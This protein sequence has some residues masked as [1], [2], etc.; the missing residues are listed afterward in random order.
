VGGG[1]GARGGTPTPPL[2][3][4]PTP[5][6]P[7]QPAP[8][9]APQWYPL[10]RP[11]GTTIYPGMQILAVNLWAAL[12][13]ASLAG[14]LGFSPAMSLND[15]C[16]FIPAWFG[17]VASVLVGLLAA[18]ASGSARAGA[19][20]ALAMSVVPAH[21]MRSVGGGY[22]NESVA[23]T[24]MCLTFWLWLR[25]LRS[26]RAWPVG[27]LAG[28][29]YAFMAAAWG[30]YIFVGN[31]VAVHAAALV[32]LGHYTPALHASYSLWFL[33]GTLVASRVPVVG[34]APYRSL[35]QAAPLLVFIGLHVL[36]VTDAYARRRR[37]DKWRARLTV[38]AVVAGT[39]A[40]V[41]VLGASTGVFGG[42][43]VRVRSL[44]L[45]HTKTGNPLVDSVAEHQAAST[46]A[47]RQYLHH[48]YLLAPLGFA[49]LL[50]K[51]SATPAG[52]VP[53]PGPNFGVPVSRWFLIL[54][55]VVGYY[56]SAR[57]ARLIILLGPVASALAGVA[58]AALLEWTFAQ[59]AMLFATKPG[60][61]AAAV[62][63]G[64]P[65]D[66]SDATPTPSKAGGKKGGD[67]APAAAAAPA[68]SSSDA[69][70]SPHPLKVF[71]GGAL[72]PLSPGYDGLAKLYA[73]PLG[74]AARVAAAGA[75][76]YGA[77][78]G[79]PA[80]YSYSHAFAQQISQPS[81][82]FR[83]R[84][85][86]GREVIV[87]DYQE[88]YW[89]LR[90]NTRACREGG[91]L[92]LRSVFSLTR[93]RP[94]HAPANRA[95]RRPAAFPPPHPP[96]R[97]QGRAR[98]VVVGLRLPDRGHRQPHDARG[99]QHV[100]PGAHCAAGPHPHVAREEGCVPVWR[101]ARCGAVV[102]ER[103][104]GLLVGGHASRRR[105]LTRG[106]PNAP[107][108][109]SAPH[110]RCCCS[111]R[112]GAP[113][114]GLRARV[115]GQPRRRPRQVAAHGAHRVVRVPRHLPARPAVPQLWLLLGPPPHAVHGGVA[116]VQAALG[117][118]RA[119]RV[120]RPA[121]VPAGV[122]VQVRPR[123]HLQG[124]QPGRELRH[125]AGWSSAC[126][127]R[128]TVT[129]ASYAPGASLM[130]LPRAPLSRAPSL[131]QVLNISEESKA[132]AADPKNRIC[133]APGS[134]Y[135]VGQY[136]PGLPLTI[137]K[138]HRHVD[139]D[140]PEHY[141]EELRGGQA[142]PPPKAQAKPAAD[143]GGAAGSTG[144]KKKKR[145]T[146]TPEPVEAEL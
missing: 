124:E 60:D 101:A 116:A 143:A 98:A 59:A 55:A 62:A 25:S 45:K 104:G 56:F 7:P 91:G 127:T 38:A 112:A 109:A 71:L 30:G 134:W 13:S 131:P 97:S 70:S 86:D 136:P 57:M 140:Q 27:F 88:A 49:I 122:L 34:W 46:E 106:C 85:N 100:E 73:S 52:A 67:K 81:L 10:G 37:L 20:A 95:C 132:W 80:F 19:G 83:A 36:A 18:E 142:P 123:A 105:A 66:A 79:V 93:S 24:A 128:Q 120:R 17:A 48:T 68:A 84:L 145:S 119:R 39:C 26:P 99:R 76:V 54:Y 72:R 125:G 108:L 33:T 138:T 50:L 69:S 9:P 87:N 28:L 35:E 6:P 92:P 11:V 110:R 22:D 74:K 43:S 2:L 44:F 53:A 14:L 31:M 47:Y 130:T 61:A 12:K 5:P 121:P 41:L 111:A 29:A 141:V 82:M 107:P 58:F 75:F 133:D 8:R 32:V 117:G 102:G 126:A 42:L 115:G 139:Y 89:W 21:L 114:G 77:V 135:C 4:P 64:P 40:A 78:R 3:T 16:V 63:G 1:E 96:R 146:P 90:D 65:V 23:M 51:G 15:V 129:A 137:P 113:P 94:P 144:K 118:R 103:G